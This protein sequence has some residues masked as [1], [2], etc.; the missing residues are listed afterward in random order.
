MKIV[1]TTIEAD[2]RI[3]PVAGSR[4]IQRSGITTS[5]WLAVDKPHLRVSS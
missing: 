1:T 3:D 5:K 2:L 4:L